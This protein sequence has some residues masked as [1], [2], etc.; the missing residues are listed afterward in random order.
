MEWLLDLHVVIHM[1]AKSKL[2]SLKVFLDESRTQKYD[3]NMAETLLRIFV[4]SQIMNYKK[5]YDHFSPKC[6]A[7]DHVQLEFTRSRKQY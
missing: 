6:I 1:Q 2:V 7:E 5:I 3:K 4:T